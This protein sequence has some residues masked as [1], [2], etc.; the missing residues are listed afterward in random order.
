MSLTP[1]T[2]VLIPGYMLNEMLWRE[3]ETYLPANCIVHHASVT[4]GRNLHDIAQHMSTCLPD[5][6]T[7]IGFSLGGYIARQFAADFPDRVESL[8]LIAS[9]LREDT[10]SEVESK[11]Q[12]VQSLSPATFKGLSSHAIAR[13]LH[14]L[15][16]SDRDMISTIQQMGR[17]L[18]FEAFITQSTLIRQG[19]P[20]ATIGCPTLVIASEDDAI[21][22]MQ[23]AEELVDAIP[24]ASLRAIKDCGHM[25]PLE[26]PEALAI[27]ITEWISV[28]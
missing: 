14:P 19:I 22:S 2:I 6:F 26:Q 15:N 25:I 9:S 7:L 1:R 28:R 18:G 21:R 5:K 11:R 20:S 23:E 16:A 13:S 27:T 4:G 24:D 3:F 12:S 8:V 17:C 10:P